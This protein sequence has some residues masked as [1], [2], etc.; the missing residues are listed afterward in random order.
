MIVISKDRKNFPSANDLAEINQY[1]RLIDDLR[2]ALSNPLDEIA[3]YDSLPLLDDWTISVRYASCLMGT[4]YGHPKFPGREHPFITSELVLFAPELAL[5]RTK[6]RW[7]RLG[8]R[9]E[10]GDA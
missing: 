2:F 7:F 5:A 8:A 1:D 10:G 6:S 9:V 3:Q 4:A